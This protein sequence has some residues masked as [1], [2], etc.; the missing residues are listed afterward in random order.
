MRR[1]GVFQ[2]IIGLALAMLAV[3]AGGAIARSEPGLAEAP[4]S[5]AVDATFGGCGRAEER[6]MCRVALGFSGIDG[7]TSYQASVQAPGGGVTFLGSLGPEGGTVWFPYSGDGTYSIDVQALGPGPDGH[8]E[9]LGRASTWMSERDGKTSSEVEH[10]EQPSEGDEQGAEGM[11]PGLEPAGPFPP[12][13]LTPPPG[14]QLPTEPVEPA[15]PV[16]EPPPPGEGEQFPTEPSPLVPSP[17]EPPVDQ[18][19]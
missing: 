13:P 18:A 19:P 6:I 10:G 15:P 9:A 14:E 8:K 7:A 11:L 3:G 2:A 4:E 5:F 16:P 17:A 1:L 12:P